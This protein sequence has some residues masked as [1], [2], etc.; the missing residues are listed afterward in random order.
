MLRIDSTKYS[1]SLGSL[2]FHLEKDEKHSSAVEAI[3]KWLRREP[4]FIASTTVVVCALCEVQT[5]FVQQN[6]GHVLGILL[7]L[8]PFV[9]QPSL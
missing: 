6:A 5:S 1:S 9:D 3:K 4:F 2:V 8:I 7:V